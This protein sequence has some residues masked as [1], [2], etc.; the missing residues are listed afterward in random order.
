M[1]AKKETTQA[2][3]QDGYDEPGFEEFVSAAH[4]LFIAMKRNRGHHAQAGAGLSLS[5][6]GL[7][8]ALA[9]QGSM[10]VGWIADQAGVAGPTATR[11]LKLLERDGVVVRQRCVE[12]ERRMLIGLTNLG[13]ELVERQRNSLRQAQQKHYASLP[14]KQ[15]ADFIRV[16]QKMTATMVNWSSE[17]APADAAPHPA[18]RKVL[19]KSS[20]PLRSSR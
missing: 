4:N 5:Q 13:R 12:D 1:S 9:D 20:K 10:P 3:T 11:M 7:L 18:R 14:P 19:Q 16:L 17:P 8:E 6:L 15:R 2:R